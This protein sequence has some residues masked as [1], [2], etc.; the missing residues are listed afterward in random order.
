MENYLAIDV[1]GTALKIGLLTEEGEILESDSKKTPKT[2]DAFYQIIEDTFHEYEGVKG[3]ALSLPGA[4]DSE[5]GIIGGSSALDYI[6]GPNIKEELEKRLQVRV[7]MENDAN[8]A[9]LAE[10]WKGA[11]S[12]VNDCC[13]IVSG[14]GIGGAVV[15]N[16]RIHKGQHLHGGEFGYMIADFNFETK[17]MKTWS[18][19]G[20]T[21]AVVRAV[22]KAK[23]VDVASLDGR[24]IFDHYH[25]DSDYE[26]AVDKYYYV[27]ANGIYNLQ[28]AYDPQKI[29]IGGGIS[30]RDDLL[31]EVNQRLDVIFHRFKHAKIRPVVLTCQYH[32]DANL[33]GALYHFLTIHS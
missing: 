4:V 6:H 2:L 33:L 7:E 29:I 11:A 3:L 24:D 19:V 23:G 27:L 10:V 21:V 13:F 9:A 12:D 5:T 26:K 25:E 28:Y 31:D 17:E 1:G 8:C 22:A 18:D 32:N 16:K 30:V 14:T 20:S 15:K